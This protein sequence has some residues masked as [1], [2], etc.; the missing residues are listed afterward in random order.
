MESLLDLSH[1][2]Y[3]LLSVDPLLPAVDRILS[4]YEQSASP[5]MKSLST[6]CIG[7][8]CRISA[9]PF[10]SFVPVSWTLF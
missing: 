10:A 9:P 4:E 5:L 2:L 1:L 6:R 8:R 3:N 7:G